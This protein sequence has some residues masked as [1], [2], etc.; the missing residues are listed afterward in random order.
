MK[1]EFGSLFNGKFGNGW[2]DINFDL[3]VDGVRGEFYNMTIHFDRWNKDER[4]Y[5]VSYVKCSD[6]D[7]IPNKKIIVYRDLKKYKRVIDDWMIGNERGIDVFTK[8][9]KVIK[10]ESRFGFVDLGFW[11]EIVNDYRDKNLRERSK[12]KKVFEL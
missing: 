3:Y 7:D 4:E 10:E 11:E 8:I 1:V 2:I 9:E 12:D 6:D 5:V